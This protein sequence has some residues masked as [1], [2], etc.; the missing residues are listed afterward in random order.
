[1]KGHEGEAENVNR[2]L[3]MNQ[4]SPN[5]CEQEEEEEERDEAH[6]QGRHREKLRTRQKCA[7]TKV[8]KMLGNDIWRGLPMMG[9]FLIKGEMGIGAWVDGWLGCQ[10]GSGLVA[11]DLEVDEL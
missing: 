1:V 8:E 10:G 2:P 11:R 9:V 3:A 5:T 4:D 7:G 6:Y